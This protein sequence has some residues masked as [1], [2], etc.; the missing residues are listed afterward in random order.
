MTPLIN[1]PNLEARYQELLVLRSRVRQTELLIA[2][3]HSVGAKVQAS[4][5]LAREKQAACSSISAGG[6]N[7]SGEMPMPQKTNSMSLTRGCLYAK[8]NN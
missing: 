3:L 7:V 8:D 1:L 6:T 4:R 2:E 5:H